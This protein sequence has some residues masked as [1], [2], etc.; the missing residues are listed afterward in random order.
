M[1]KAFRRAILYF[2]PGKDP[3]QVFY[4]LMEWRKNPTTERTALHFLLRSLELSKK[5]DK[6]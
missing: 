6:R 2:F 3:D 1:T 4:S 5:F